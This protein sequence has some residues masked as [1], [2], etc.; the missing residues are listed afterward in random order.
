MPS[1]WSW[2]SCGSI[3][4][5]CKGAMIPAPDL[6]YEQGLW[7]NGLRSIAGLD[8]AGRGA[9]AGPVAVGAVILPASGQDLLR[10]L[11]G[12]RASKLMTPLAR[13]RLRPVVESCAL[14]WGVGFASAAEI[15]EKGIAAATRLT[16]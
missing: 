7:G 13:S 12:V 6:S 15:D 11:R 14:R 3:P 8:E 16:A 5:R 10:E 2:T 1:R 4:T 9:L